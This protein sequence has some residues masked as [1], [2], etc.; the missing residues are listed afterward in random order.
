MHS[1]YFWCDI[2]HP[3]NMG[4]WYSWSRLWIFNCFDLLLC[5]KN[6][7]KRLMI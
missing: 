4:R 5:G 6:I 2:V 1:K 7:L 3:I